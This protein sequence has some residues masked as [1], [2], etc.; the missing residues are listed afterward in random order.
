MIY[1]NNSWEKFFEGWTLAK[2][3]KIQQNYI[4]LILKYTNKNSKLLEIASGSGFTSIILYHSDRKNLIVSDINE[5]LLN[6]IK[7][8]ESGFCVKKV[9]S[10]NIEEENVDCIFHQGFLEHFDDENIIKLLKE[11]GRVSDLIIFDVPN[12]HRWKK[13]KEYGNERFLSPN[14]WKKL[15][16]DANLEI[17]EESGRRLSFI[18]NY[19]PQIISNNKLIRKIFGTSSIFVCKKR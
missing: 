17:I 4:D 15:I 13:I 11:Q 12:S 5:N 3:I 16:S 9:N 10:F 1:Y 8:E 7:K 6:M 18:F 19:F 2:T 14:K